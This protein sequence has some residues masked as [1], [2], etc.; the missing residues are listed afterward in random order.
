MDKRPL[1]VNWDA[2]I[3]CLPTCRGADEPARYEPMHAGPHLMSKFRSTV[4]QT[5]G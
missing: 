1:A 3:E 4:T 5:Q 2:S